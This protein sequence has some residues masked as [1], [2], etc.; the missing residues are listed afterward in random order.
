MNIDSEQSNKY[1]KVLENYYKLKNKYEKKRHDYK[2]TFLKKNPQASIIEK[3]QAL[4][5]FKKRRKCINCNQTGGTIFTREGENLVAYCNCIQP[6]NLNINIK[7]PTIIGITDNLENL[8]HD[9]N[10]RKRI[11][12]EYK[13]DLLFELDNEEV[14]LNEFQTNKDE[15]ETLL[16][17]HSNLTEIN[18]N[19]NEKI[20]IAIEG[21]EENITVNK[22]QYLV[23]KQKQLN[24]LVNDYKKNISEY[25]KS[26][27]ISILNDALLIYKNVILPLQ[28]EIRQYKYQKIFIDSHSKSNTGK[29]NKKEMPVY[30]ITKQQISIENRYV[31][32]EDFEI[33][34][35][36][37]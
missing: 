20:S 24:N 17:Y 8:K 22:K 5:D 9:I 25:K 26:G 6:C 21:S 14:I 32:N 16:T 28:N 19:L 30:H 33:I 3:K 34:E 4:E 36:K 10:E 1:M 35:N 29:I 15:L 7:P 12:T 31:N 11:I 23:D 18:E 2:R 37:K 13:L 27:E